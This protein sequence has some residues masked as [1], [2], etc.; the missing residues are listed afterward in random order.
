MKAPLKAQLQLQCRGVVQGVGF[1]PWV[2]RLASALGLHGWLQ[3]VAGAVAIELNGERQ[4]LELFLQRMRSELPAPARL[5][6]LEPQWGPFQA[7]QP[8]NQAKDQAPAVVIRSSPA[9]GVALGVGLVAPAL[10]ADLAPCASCLAEL[11]DPTNRRYGYPFI[12]CSACGPRYSIATA[13]PY[14]RAHT[15]LASFP[16]CPAC[17]QEFEDPGDR[18]F[19]AETIGCCSCGPQLEFWEETKQHQGEPIEQALGLLEGG[20]ILALQGVGGF[21]LLVDA[22]DA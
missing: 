13:E 18:R 22:G 3:N 20:G 12:S 8:E 17:R 21:Q 9:A 16:L 15:S 5:E 1:R 14:G 4:N 2:Q 7:L 6:S 10:V 11:R 19:H